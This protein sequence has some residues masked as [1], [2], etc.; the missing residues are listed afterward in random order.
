[1]NLHTTS[2]RKFLQ[3]AATFAAAATTGFTFK[4]DKKLLAF[5]TLGCPEWTLKQ[6][7]DFA[8]RHN[9]K[10]IE[11]RGILKQMDLP[12][13][14]D[15]SKENIPSTLRMMSDNGLS[16]VNLGSSVVL[17]LPDGAERKKNF[18]DAKR[19]IDLAQQLK[20]PYIRVFP[21]IFPKDQEKSATMDLMAK[22]LLEL[23][24]YAKNSNVTVLTE[25][26]GDLVYADDLEKVMKAAEHP[27]VGMIWDVCNMWIKTKESPKLVYSKLKKYI[28]HT[29][30]KNAKL[31]GDKINYTFIRQGDVPVFEA[32]DLL[33]KGG[34]KG[35]Y[36]FEWE[37]L[38]HP[39]LEAPELAF[40]DY[41]DVMSKYL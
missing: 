23:G 21:N 12:L 3:T 37:K 15:F 36:C 10:G 16:F 27:H 18:D 33:K 6:I 40:A 8:T 9:Y 39:E 20:C 7:V 5:S 32:V 26:H 41:T 28:H 1:M 24:D 17:H 11:V 13:C 31:D 25:S 19:F 22:G 38:W 35:Y 34:Y 29:H 14:P 30:I 2:R 4:D